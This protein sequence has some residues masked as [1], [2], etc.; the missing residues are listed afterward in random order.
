MIET[1]FALPVRSP[2]PFIVPWTCVGAGLDG[3]Q[4]VGHAALGVVVAVD[5]DPRGPRA[6]ASTTAA[7]AACTCEGSDEPFVSQSATV[8]A[9]A[10][11]A[12]WT[13]ASA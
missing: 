13:Q 9:P 4:R 1:R 11:A 6:S 12:A 10:S 2:M 3:G 5:P 8:S 7:V